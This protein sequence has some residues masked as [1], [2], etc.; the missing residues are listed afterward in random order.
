MSFVQI[1]EYDTS[2]PGEADAL[3]D[4]W[5]EA[6]AGQRKAQRSTR[7]KDRAQ[8]NTYMYVVEFPSYDVAMENSELPA[9]SEFAEGMA[10][11]CDRGPEFRDLDV[12]RTDEL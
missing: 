7:Y 5:V 1:I 10:K 12:D 11:L 8:P 3:L 6:T 9:T 2:R 4:R